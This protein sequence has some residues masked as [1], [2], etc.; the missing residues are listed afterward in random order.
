[1]KNETVMW[2]TKDGD[3]VKGGEFQFPFPENV[4]EAIDAYGEQ[5]V[6]LGL[7]KSV[8]IWI[9][10][11]ARREATKE[12]NPMSV[13]DIAAKAASMKPE[14]SEREYTDPV[15]RIADQYGKLSDEQKTKLLGSLRE[16]LAGTGQEAAEG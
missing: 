9:Q 8:T 3:V 10:A 11:W 12:E 5:T 4:Q 2:K 16:M 7:K 1:M 14:F 15:Q 6:L 13:A